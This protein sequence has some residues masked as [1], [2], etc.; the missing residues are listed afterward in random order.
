MLLAV[1]PTTLNSGFALFVVFEPGGPV[2]DDG[3]SDSDPGVAAPIVTVSVPLRALLPRHVGDE[4]LVGVLP[5]R[6]QALHVGELEGP[7]GRAVGRRRRPTSPSRTRLTDSGRLKFVSSV[8]GVIVTST[9][10]FAFVVWP[11]DG[12]PGF[13]ASSTGV[14]GVFG[15]FVS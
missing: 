1:V 6:E 7:G 4:H 11:A 2:Y 14:G 12:L 3:S 10:G 5:L 13:E 8:V 15:W 9:T